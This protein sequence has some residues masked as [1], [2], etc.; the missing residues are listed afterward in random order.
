MQVDQSLSNRQSRKTPKDSSASGVKNGGI[1]RRRSIASSRYSRSSKIQSTKATSQRSKS[2]LCEHIQINDED[3]GDN[4]GQAIEQLNISS[5]SIATDNMDVSPQHHDDHS[6]TSIDNNNQNERPIKKHELLNQY[7]TKLNTRGYYYKLCDGTKKS[8]R[9]PKQAIYSDANL[10]SHLARQ[11]KLKHVLYPSQCL[12]H[13]IKPQLLSDDMKKKIDNAL[14]CAIIKDSCPFGDFQKAGFQHFLQVVLSDTNYKAPHRT[15]IRKR[16]AILYRSY[17]KALIDELSS[18]SD[19]ALTADSWSSP[20]RVHFVC[21][22]AHYYDKEFGYISKVISFRRFIGRSFAVRLRQFIRS[23][24]KKLKISNKICSFTTDNGKVRCLNFP[25][26]SRK[27]SSVQITTQEEKEEE[28]GYTDMDDEDQIW[29]DDIESNDSN[30]SD[31]SD[32]ESTNDY[33]NNDSPDYED[34]CPEDSD[35]DE[36]SLS[37]QP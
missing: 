34:S 3:D 35:K 24:L 20:C 8:H 31:V 11:H 21:I 10:R 27:R 19:L 5:T 28:T 26:F 29:K 6:V 4:V 14:I 23:K 22:T 17:R 13:Q 36:E 1:S 33:S 9:V 16:M 15:T 25:I 30:G 2:N 32:G 37:Q 12:Q 18:V 7:F